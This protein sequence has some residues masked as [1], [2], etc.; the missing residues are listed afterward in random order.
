MPGTLPPHFY[1]IA[2]VD[3]RGCPLGNGLAGPPVGHELRHNFRSADRDNG[4]ATEARHLERMIERR[5][6]LTRSS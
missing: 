3:V 1:L 4:A 2:G 5:L 6:R